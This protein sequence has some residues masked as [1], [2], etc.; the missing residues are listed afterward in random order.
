[1][2]QEFL[3]TLYP[4]NE[5]IFLT[6]NATYLELPVSINIVLVSEL[7]KKNGGNR[8]FEYINLLQ[9]S[10]RTKPQVGKSLNF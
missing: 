8:K 5:N 7:I 4:K 10:L 1:M 3:A 2:T 6:L 9:K